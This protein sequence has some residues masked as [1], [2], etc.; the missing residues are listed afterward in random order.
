M[1]GDNNVPKMICPRCSIDL[2]AAAKLLEIITTS[3]QHFESAISSAVNLGASGSQNYKQ[4]SNQT[5]ISKRS[6]PMALPFVPA[7]IYRNS[8][9]GQETEV[10]NVLQTPTCRQYINNSLGSVNKGLPKRK[11]VVLENELISKKQNSPNS[12]VDYQPAN[13]VLNESN[14]NISKS[15]TITKLFKK[16]VLPTDQATA[17]L[18]NKKVWEIVKVVLPDGK[19]FTMQFVKGT[20]DHMTDKQ[21]EQLVRKKFGVGAC[22]TKIGNDVNEG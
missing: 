16:E 22:Y 5:I 12:I 18:E 17:S 3:R 9:I 6:A 11:V 19:K 15:I 7:K 1:K 21:L 10:T 13:T 8:L 2:A 4:I 20:T 14:F